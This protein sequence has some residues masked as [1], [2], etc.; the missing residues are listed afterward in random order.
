M[1]TTISRKEDV[2]GMSNLVPRR[3]GLSADI[4]SEHKGC[5][6]NVGHR[7]TPRIKI[8][9]GDYEV[10]VSI[11]RHPEILA[12]SGNAKHSDRASI[13]EAM[14][15]IGRNYDLFLKHFMDVN[16]EYDDEDLFNDLRSRGEYK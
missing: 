3:T 10:S 5:K 11:D 8:T 4:W 6:R 13:K 2:F 12:E 9:K 15:Y 16:D 1:K 7:F 14:K